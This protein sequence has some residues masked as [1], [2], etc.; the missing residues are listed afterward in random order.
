MVVALHHPQAGHTRALGCPLHFSATPTA[1]ERPAPLLGEHTREVLR[2]AG[3]SDAQIAAL[4]DCGA[5][6]LAAGA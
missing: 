2:E 1:I 5:I 6:A 3:Y 4:A